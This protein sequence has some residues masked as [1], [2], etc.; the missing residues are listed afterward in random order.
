[1][2]TWKEVVREKI[3]F[4]LK[5]GEENYGKNS[6]SPKRTSVKGKPLGFPED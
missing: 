4:L 3:R 5:D 1:V 6:A 2:R